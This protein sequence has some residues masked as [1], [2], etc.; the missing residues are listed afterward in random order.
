MLTR[1]GGDMAVVSKEKVPAHAQYQ[2]HYR[3]DDAHKGGRRKI[4]LHLGK[5]R[6][7]PPPLSHPCTDGREKVMRAV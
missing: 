1:I 4:T 3:R 6:G 2:N 5:L 7:L